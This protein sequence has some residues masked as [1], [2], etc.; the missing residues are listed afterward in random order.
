MKPTT[1]KTDCLIRCHGE[2]CSSSQCCTREKLGQ[3]SPSEESLKHVHVINKKFEKKEIIPASP[4]IDLKKFLI[5]DDESPK[6]ASPETSGPNNSEACQSND[7]QVQSE[8][9]NTNDKSS[10]SI[11]VVINDQKLVAN[12]SSNDTVL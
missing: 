11:S 12:D 9:D 6:L 1:D 7:K 5:H 2:L 8:K 10:Y 4:M 3:K